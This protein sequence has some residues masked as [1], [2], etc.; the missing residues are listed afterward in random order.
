MRKLFRIFLTI[1]YFVI[2]VFVINKL[3]NHFLP[4]NL[5]TDIITLVCWVIALIASVAL[6]EYTMKKLLYNLIL[7]EI[8][9]VAEV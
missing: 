3:I 6:A 9:K 7:R 8:V 2:F 4:I 5:L 1:V